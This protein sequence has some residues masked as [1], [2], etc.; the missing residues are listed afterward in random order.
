MRSAALSVSLQV[1]ALKPVVREFAS[2]LGEILH[3][4]SQ[5]PQ[6]VVERPDIH[7]AR[8]SKPINVLNELFCFDM[9]ALVRPKCRE[10]EKRRIRIFHLLVMRKI[11]N[12]IVSCANNLDVHFLQQAAR[13]IL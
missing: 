8:G 6:K 12:R 2:I 1:H 3:P 9:N 13:G 4:G 5:G 7:I 10:H 11:I